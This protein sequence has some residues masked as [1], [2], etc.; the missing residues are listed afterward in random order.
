M[1]L[2]EVR[3]GRGQARRARRRCLREL[4]E[5]ARPK[6]L[7]YFYS[8]AVP[9]S[10]NPDD[11]AKL[12]RSVLARLDRRS[13]GSWACIVGRTT[14]L[15]PCRSFAP[16][17]W[18][19]HAHG[20]LFGHSELIAEYPHANA[21]PTGRP[22]PWSHVALE[23]AMRRC[24]AKVA[25]KHGVSIDMDHA[26]SQKLVDV[27]PLRAHLSAGASELDAPNGA[28]SD[29][30]L[31]KDARDCTEYTWAISKPHAAPPLS[32]E[33]R[34]ALQLAFPG[35]AASRSGWFRSIPMFKA[36]LVAEQADSML[37]QHPS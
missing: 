12:I 21:Y 4:G 17:E 27:R 37:C 1:V 29:E 8:L 16:G 3:L 23:G 2:H 14:L 28:A 33:Q 7:L 13:S 15:D 31:S 6:A 19:L 32:H 26:A 30:A 18:F 24:L 11:Q 25:A 36:R 35:R 9:P 20:V 34:V 10:D 22:R 5:G